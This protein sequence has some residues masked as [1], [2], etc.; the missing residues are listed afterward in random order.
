MLSLCLL[1]F[2]LKGLADALNTHLSERFGDLFEDTR[3]QWMRSLEPAGRVVHAFDK[4]TTA[5]WRCRRR[6]HCRFLS[7]VPLKHLVDFT[8]GLAEQLAGFG[9]EMMRGG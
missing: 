6:F 1:S 3:E 5:N 9:V 2:R 8:R 7:V 4:R